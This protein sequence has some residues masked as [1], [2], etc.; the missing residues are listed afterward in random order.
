MQI[1]KYR[2]NLP[3]FRVVENFF[4]HQEV[5]KIID[6]EELQNFNKGRVGNADGQFDSN[7]RDSDISWLSRSKESDW[8]FFK[9]HDLVGDVNHDCFMYDIDGFES[10]QYTKYKK[11][12]HYSWHFDAYTQYTTWERRISAVILLTD[13]QKYEGGELQVVTNGNIEQPM[14]F[15]PPAG[16]VVFFASWMPHRVVPVQKGIRKSLVAWIM[17]KRVC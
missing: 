7:V 14:T 17:G 12:Q 10:F 2:R 3:Q 8:L 5:E 11:G 16:S 6:L 4:N 9:F 15:K 13:P 1:V